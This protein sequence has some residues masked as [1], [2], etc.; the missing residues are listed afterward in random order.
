MTGMSLPRFFELERIGGRRRAVVESGGAVIAVCSWL[1]PKDAGVDLEDAAGAVAARIRGGAM[2]VRTYHAALSSGEAVR[3][4]GEAPRITVESDR[5]SATEVLVA[6]SPDGARTL[7]W[8]RDGAIAGVLRLLPAAGA[9]PWAFEIPGWEEPL[10]ALSVLFAAERLL[11]EAE[12]AAD[13]PA[14]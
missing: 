14:R 6:D 9:E 3:V 10:R 13:H 4:F 12:A 11:H 5:H 8:S 1:G 7:T 2:P